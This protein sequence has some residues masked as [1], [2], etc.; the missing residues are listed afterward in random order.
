MRALSYFLGI[1]FYSEMLKPSIINSYLK[2]Y[3]ENDMSES[4]K[5]ENFFDKKNLDRINFLIKY[6]LFRYIYIFLLRV[7]SRILFLFGNK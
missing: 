5:I 6:D 4:D 2:Y 7:K 1:E 3:K